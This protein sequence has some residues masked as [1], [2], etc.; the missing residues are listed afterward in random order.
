MRLSDIQLFHAVYE[1]GSFTGAANNLDIPPAS[2]SRKINK[3]E[4]KLE[5]KL[6]ICL[7]KRTT[8]SLHITDV[9]KHFYNRTKAIQQDFTSLCEE[10]RQ[11]NEHFGGKIRIQLIPESKVLIPFLHKFQRE[12]PQITLDLVVSGHDLNIIKYGIDMAIKVGV[13]RDSSFIYRKLAFINQDIVAAPSYIKKAGIP[14]DFKDLKHHNCLLFR[15]PDGTVESTWATSKGE[16]IKVTGNLIA[17]D[18]SLIK[19]AT[20]LGQGVSCLP[21]LLS[22]KHI[23]AGT[24]KKLFPTEAPVSDDI[25]LR[26][27]LKSSIAAHIY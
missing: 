18:I 9:G 5:N 6:G 10:V 12:Y 8:R 7:F 25:C 26:S 17:D 27:R 3:L 24:L 20:L 14:S 16:E 11:E 15:K 1:A 2:I 13:Q 22:D 23:K 21:R 19:E 4:N